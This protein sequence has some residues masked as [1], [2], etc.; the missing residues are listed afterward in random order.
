MFK[1]V[2][3]VFLFVILSAGSAWSAT[4]LKVA[5]VSDI[6]GLDPHRANDTMSSH[7][8]KQVYNYLVALDK[9]LN[10]VPDLA[11]SWENPDDLTWVF[12][13]RKGVLFHN[14]EEFTAEDVKFTIERMQDPETRYTGTALRGKEMDKVEV[15]DRYTV[16][17]TTKMPFQPLLFGLT[18]HELA[19]LNEKAVKAAGENYAK[20]P[21][22]TGPFKFVE[23]LHG[24]RVVLEKN[25]QYFQGVPKIDRLIFRAI[26]E[27]STRIVE[28][29]SGGVDLIHSNLPA[30]DYDRLA[31]NPNLAVYRVRG[32]S[33]HMA[34]FNMSMQPFSDKR[35][36][37]AMNYAIDKKAMVDALFFGYANPARGPMSPSIVGFDP[38]LPESYPYNPE[39]ARELLK[40]AGYANG[41][42]CKIYTD[43]RTE[44]RNVV[45]FLQ[46]NLAE[47]GIKVEIEL[48]EWSVFLAQTSKGVEGLYILAVFGTGDAD[49]A[50]HPRYYSPYIGSSNRQQWNNPAL[51]KLLEEG[52]AELDQQKAAAIYK[53]IQAMVV[54][55][56]PELFL[57]VAEEL[58]ASHKNVKGFHPSPIAASFFPLYIE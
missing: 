11:T 19:M 52:R 45:E 10:I 28:L 33:S 36:R 16:K 15:V 6:Q 41:F 22:G 40:E 12:H 17:I 20:Q 25:E 58:A 46:M 13:L 53:T 4:E 18:R 29:E 9:E 50:M 55:E 7:V 54:E 56:A 47:V 8:L 23:W 5:Q 27:A 21:V 24:D 39:K 31:Q 44:R 34:G 30:Q 14:G 35:V 32:P 37:Q 43:P 2:L 38:S 26:P 42:S 1:K 48:L 51:D 49:G 57:V 3:V